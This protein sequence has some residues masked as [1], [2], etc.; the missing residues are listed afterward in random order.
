MT[1]R[2][3]TNVKKPSGGNLQNHPLL[4]HNSTKELT[5]CR[6][7]QR[8]ARHRHPHR[9]MPNTAERGG[10]IQNDGCAGQYT[11]QEKR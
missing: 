4:T 6:G 9:R 3:K 8:L 5:P 11:P 10:R 2:K 7:K 1:K